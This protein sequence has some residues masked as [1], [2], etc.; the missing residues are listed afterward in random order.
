MCHPSREDDRYDMRRWPQIFGVWGAASAC[1]GCMVSQQGQNLAVGWDMDR[2]NYQTIASFQTNDGRAD[3]RRRLGTG[4]YDVKVEN[5]NLLPAVLG[6]NGTPSIV[7]SHEI[8]G[9]IITVIQASTSSCAIRYIMFSIRLGISSQAN[10]G[11]CNSLY[12]FSPLA[13]GSGLVATEAKLDG[14]D[15][16]IY[17][18]H[19][20]RAATV[21]GPLFPPP[22]PVRRAE[23]LEISRPSPMHNT[24]RSR[25]TPQ[26]APLDPTDGASRSQA[27]APAPAAVSASTPANRPQPLT[28]IKTIPHVAVGAPTARKPQHK[29]P[30]KHV[31]LKLD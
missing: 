12:Y 4:L 21:D 17:H 20:G 9:E 8:N 6:I 10:I 2:A 7:Y 27:A 18:V 3:L 1:A 23:A 24:R 30:H 31:T 25:S 26:A 28:H 5:S 22:L 29:K 16:W 14:A 19:P 11:N 15:H 13:D